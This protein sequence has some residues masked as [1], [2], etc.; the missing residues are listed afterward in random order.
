MSAST[1]DSATWSVTDAKESQQDLSK[2]VS[3]IL[4]LKSYIVIRYFLEFTFSM[5][6]PNI[7]VGG[8]NLQKGAENANS[9]DDDGT[10]NVK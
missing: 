7:Q 4:C 10:D 1:S 2:M 6:I 3:L 5:L 9:T 8:L